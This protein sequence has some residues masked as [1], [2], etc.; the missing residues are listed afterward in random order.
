MINMPD[1]P[2]LR[3]VYQRKLLEFADLTPD[4]ISE[5]MQYEEQK[6]QMLGSGMMGLPPQQPG[7]Q[8]QPQQQQ[9]QTMPLQLQ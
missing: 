6:M 2:K 1:N 7:M 4:E 3:E 9:A 5:I 8:T